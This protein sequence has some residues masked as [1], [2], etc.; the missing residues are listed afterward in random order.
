MKQ[1]HQRGEMP[2]GSSGVIQ[3]SV[4]ACPVGPSQSFLDTSLKHCSNLESSVNMSLPTEAVSPKATPLPPLPSEDPLTPAQWKTLLAI[5]DAVIPA[6]KPVS[7]ADVKTEVAVDDNSYSTA[8]SA[9]R[10]LTPEDDPNAEVAAKEYL[11]DNA[12]SNPAFKMQMQRIFAMYMPQSTKKELSMVLS[13]LKYVIHQHEHWFCADHQ[14]RS[15]I[16]RGHRETFCT[17]Q[18][19]C[20]TVEQYSRRITCPNRLPHTHQRA[21]GTYTRIHHFGLGDR[22]ARSPSPTPPL[23]NRALETNMD[24]NHTHATPCHGCSPRARWDEIW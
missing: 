3:K 14:S 21:T 7:T 10:A 8:V 19:H 17:T 18:L 12:S 5:S 11:A 15:Y 6:I 4:P 23:A 24:Q 2:L 20:L 13:I 9:L 22:K 1:R 16:A